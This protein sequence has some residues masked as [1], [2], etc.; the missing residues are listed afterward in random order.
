LSAR[1]GTAVYAQLADTLADFQRTIN[2]IERHIQ[3]NQTK[4]DA[5]VRTHRHTGKRF[6]QLCAA[7]AKVQSQVYRDVVTGLPSRALF[8]DRF[9]QALLRA[10]RA[11]RKIALL[12]VDLDDFKEVNDTYGHTVGDR[13]LH[14]VAER[15][16]ACLRG[17]DTACRYGGDEFLIMLPEIDDRTSL[18][19]VAEKIQT[20]L[21]RPYVL[22]SAITTITASVGTAI[23]PVDGNVSADLIRKADA[24]MYSRKRSRRH[25]AVTTLR[26]DILPT[27]ERP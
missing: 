18:T 22:D 14:Q 13:L 25:G 5:L 24:A 11:D 6:T 27:S 20:A 19:V 2:I 7:L 21:A 4:I 1:T 26:G 8:M 16:T 15:V 12:F 3:A 10:T 17:E 9:N 23:Y